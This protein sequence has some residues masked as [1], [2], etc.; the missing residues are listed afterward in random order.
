MAKKVKLVDAIDERIL[1]LL[2]EQKKYEP[3][4]DKSKAIGFEIERLT[5][6]RSELE[7]NRAKLSPDT[8]LTCLVSLG[9]TMLVLHY[10]ELHCVTTKAFQFMLKPKL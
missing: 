8:I 3:T 9:S 2:E 7:R 5:K 10:E 4:E 6:A 1:E